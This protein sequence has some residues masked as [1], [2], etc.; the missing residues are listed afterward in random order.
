MKTASSYL[1]IIVLL[2]TAA[3][4]I[5]A[6]VPQPVALL[7]L[8]EQSTREPSPTTP[9]PSIFPIRAAFYY[10]WFPEAW[11]QQGFN[12]FTNY[13]P[14]LDFYDSSAADVIH[15]HIQ[16]LSYG[17]FQAAILSWWGQG[18]PTDQ[19]VSTILAAI[20]ASS[21]PSFHVALYYE[22]ESIGDPAV[23]QIQNDLAYIRDHYSQDASYLR[24]DGRFVIFVYSGANDS[25]GMADRWMQANHGLG[26]PAYVV[27]RVF[28]G[29]K[30]CSSQPDSWHQYAP[31]GAVKDQKG[32]SIT[33]SPGFWKKGEP[34]AR[35]PRDLNAWAASVQAML[36]SGEPWQLVTTFNEWGE[37]TAVESAQ[38]WSTL[39]GFG[40]YLDVLHKYTVSSNVSNP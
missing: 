23:S 4:S 15:A 9:A 8:P 19:R 39:S 28:P 2:L 1:F 16:A 30:A 24:V 14:S 34:S 18:S 25:C 11:K 12:P 38:Q 21:N 35:L 5:Q 40:A 20:H 26:N 17:G 27:L 32:Y 22:N 6:Q 33:I 29:Y 10:P 37:G 31:A 7:S 3:C 13:N 36:A